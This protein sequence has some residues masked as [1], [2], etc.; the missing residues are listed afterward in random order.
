M[1]YLRNPTTG[2]VRYA[3]PLM[4]KRLARYGW[5]YVKRED[6]VT[7]QRAK[8]QQLMPRHITGHRLTVH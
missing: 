3:S 5:E 7:Y 8:I 4:A 1:K 2:E 6:W